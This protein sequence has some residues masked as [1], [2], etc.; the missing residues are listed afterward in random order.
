MKPSEVRDL[1]TRDHMQIR[2]LAT[3]ADLECARFL[4]G[5]D[6]DPAP[7]ILRLSQALWGHLAMED[8]LLVPALREVDGWGEVRAAEV[9]A[10]H[11][12]Q[13]EELA[14]LVRVARTAAREQVA[15]A[16]RGLIAALRVDM[17]REEHT[18]LS[19]DL[20]RDDPVVVDQT[21]G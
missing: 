9:L 3:E 1:I 7:I 14:V 18:L 13:R 4:T 11:G 20:L 5:E 19:R 21:D 17:D 2:I 6:I 10:E 16:A 15:K 8:R 12:H